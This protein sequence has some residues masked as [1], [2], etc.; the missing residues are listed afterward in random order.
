MVQTNNKT[1]TLKISYNKDFFLYLI[2]TN[3]VLVFSTDLDKKYIHIPNYVNIVIKD[4]NLEFVYDEKY[5]ILFNQFSTTLDNCLKNFRRTYRKK[6][7]LK[8]LGYRVSISDDKKVLMLK[9]G[10]SHTSFLDIPITRLN[11]KVN[12]NF[13]TVEGC[14]AVEVGNFASK[15][16]QLRRPDVYKGK[17]VWYKNEIKVLKELKKK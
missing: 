7:F 9:L 6:L 1:K 14:D 4:K 16:R 15:I 10:Y 8:G 5:E 3:Y 2:K 12:K 11:V 13:I 17:G